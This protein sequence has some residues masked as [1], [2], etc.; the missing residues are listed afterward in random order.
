MFDADDEYVLAPLCMETWGWVTYIYIYTHMYIYIYIC[1]DLQN[2]TSVLN[3]A[4][5]SPV[6]DDSKF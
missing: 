3:L 6:L 2:E 1:S 5:Q 4:M